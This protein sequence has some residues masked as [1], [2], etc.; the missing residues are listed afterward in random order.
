MTD[1]KTCPYCGEEILSVAKKCKHCCEWQNDSVSSGMKPRNSFKKIGRYLLR[2]SVVVIGVAITLSVSQWLNNRSDKKEMA[3]YLNA[4]KLELEANIK[5]LEHVKG[6]F[7]GDVGYS[8]YLRSNNK[9]ML[10]QDTIISYIGAAY[11]YER[12]V[13]FKTS[14]FE[15][16]KSSGN[17]R[18]IDNEFLMSL[19]DVYQFKLGMY[20]LCDWYYQIKFDEMKPELP[21]LYEG[22]IAG[23]PMF[24]FFMSGIQL[25]I[26]A[27]MER[28]IKEFEEMAERLG[29]LKLL[30]NK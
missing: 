5:Q 21:A 9:N 15:R 22:R 18:L 16:F 6:K 24:N 19:M 7:Q 25:G 10:N 17:L 23:I 26:L 2:V 4:V 11:N 20:E 30:K 1:V 14:A 13:P 12:I 8:N 3:Q 28:Y 29:N 27:E